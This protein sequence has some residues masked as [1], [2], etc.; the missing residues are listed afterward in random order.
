MEYLIIGILTG[1]ALVTAG[2]FL[3]LRLG[4]KADASAIT[5]PQDAQDQEMQR[6]MQDRQRQWD[7]LMN[8]TGRRANE[9]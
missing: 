7:E 4:G 5:P 2:L 1:G 9:D 3:G 6:I 8:Y